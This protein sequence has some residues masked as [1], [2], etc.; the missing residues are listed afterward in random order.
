VSPGASIEPS[1]RTRRA[2]VLGRGELTGRALAAHL[3]AAADDWLA[4]VFVAAAGPAATD[5][6]LLA[7]GGF[8]RGELAPGSDLDLVIVHRNRPDIARIAEA[9]WYPVW[10]EGVALDH[11]VRTARE[12]GAAMDDDL[13]VA[14]GLLDVRTIAGS[15]ALGDEVRRA[16]L[17][18]WVGRS[19]RWLPA[20][21]ET[22]RARHEAAGDLAF[23]LEPDLKEAR[24]GLRDLYQLLALARVVPVLADLVAEGRLDPPADVLTSVRVELQRSTGRPTNRLTLQDQDTVAGALG[25]DADALVAA[26]ADAARTVA[27][28]SDD[29]WRRIDRMLSGRR[30]RR[31]W[32]P[33]PI[34]PGLVVRGGEIELAFGAD[35][36]RDATL[37]LRA[38]AASAELDLPIAREALDRFVGAA[39]APDGVWP[40]DLRE[41]LLRLLSAGRPAIAAWETL[42]QQGVIVK[43]IPEWAAVRNR[44]QR[45][46]YHRF[47]VDRHLLETVA[48]TSEHVREVERPDLLHL[49]ALLHDLGKGRPGDH[50]DAGIE[51][52]GSIGPRLGLPAADIEVLQTMVRL[53]LLLPETATRRDLDDPVTIETVAAAVGDRDTL[54]LL[55][56]LVEADSRA[57]G[58]A[59]STPWKAG[60]VARLVERTGLRLDG[61]P[62]REPAPPTEDQRRLLAAGRLEVRA[63]G[64]QVTIAAPDRPGLLSTVAGVLALDGAS[65]RSAATRSFPAPD[66]REGPPMALLVLQVQPTWDVL[67]EAPRLARDLEAALAGALPLAERLGKRERSQPRRRADRAGA[68]CGAASV[69]VTMDNAASDVATVLEVHAPD[70]LG[71]LWRITRAVSQAGLVITAALVSTLGADVVDAFYVQTADG[72]KLPDDSDRPEVVRHTIVEALGA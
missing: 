47:T 30:R 46:A 34:E 72:R 56:A 51:L 31:Q 11:S 55:A 53:H 39:P 22:V 35:P 65:V 13:R 19:K 3:A 33:D 41:A 36:A 16:S 44:P 8:G 48:N 7:V 2:E 12:V 24:G 64:T 17:D 25:T 26:V 27:W 50:T 62:P 37:A 54:H 18:K 45:N 57:T 15:A 29:G 9:V 21:G 1:L 71:S 43:L 4:S 49:G 59:A 66:D 14:L 69:V 10:D 32:V 52:V 6:A 5:V 42:D 68:A 70:R 60:L 23:L 28:A 67:P 63:T 38:A 61:H 58:P 20:V 40:D